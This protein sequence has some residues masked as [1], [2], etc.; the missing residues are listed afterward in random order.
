MK[1]PNSCTKNFW[2][3]PLP[4]IEGDLATAL[5]LLH[6]Y[7]E[8]KKIPFALIGALVPAILLHLR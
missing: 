8:Q 1:R 7:F 2:K 4:K 3:T 5:T 6:K